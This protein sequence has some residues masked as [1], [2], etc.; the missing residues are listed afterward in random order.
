MKVAILGFGLEGEA[1]LR[2]FREKNATVTVFD[3]KSQVEQ[4]LPADVHFR[5]IKNG[6]FHA[7]GFD[8]VVRGPAIHPDRVITESALTSA[9]KLF[10]QDC[11][12]HIVGVTGSKGKGTTSSYIFGMLTRA[13]VRAHLVGNIGTAALDVLPDIRPSDVVVFELSSFQ[14]WDMT[15]SPHVAV[16]LMIEPDHLDVHRNVNEYISAKANITRWQK[17][18]DIV[19]FLPDDEHSAKIAKLSK[20]TKLG[21]GKPPAAYVKNDRFVIDEHSICSVNDLLLPGHH[22]ILNACAAITAAWQYA[23]NTTAIAEALKEFSGL[24][25]RLKFVA[26]KH[27]VKYYDDSIATTPGSAIAAIKA[28]EQPKVLILGGSSKGVDFSDLATALTN[29][30]MRRVLLI[31]DEAPR[32]AEALD[33]VGFVNYENL[34]YIGMQELVQLVADVAEPGDVAILSPACASFG[35]FENY[36]D[37]GDQFIAAV[38]GL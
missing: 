28:F 27:G 25:H 3:E 14:L 37:R 21:Y 15:T 35:M 30:D 17:K 24:E 13:G 20:G 38:Q 11:P 34:A 4:K 19:I 9:T 5:H 22:N 8:L 12:A 26:E 36:K 18:D 1:V 23:Q 31:G 7:K 33:A 2:H 6:Q 32:I 29:A 10:F 16:V